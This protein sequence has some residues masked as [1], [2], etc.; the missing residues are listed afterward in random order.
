MLKDDRPFLPYNDEEQN[1][2][3]LKS[4]AEDARPLILSIATLGD[5]ANEDSAYCVFNSE[6]GS[7]MVSR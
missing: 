6:R 2:Q 3:C 1:R 5:E 7:L 4:L